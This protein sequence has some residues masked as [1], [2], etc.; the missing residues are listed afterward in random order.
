MVFLRSRAPR[1]LVVLAACLLACAAAPALAKSDTPFGGAPWPVPGSIEAEDFDKGGQGVSYYNPDDANIYGQY[2][3]NAKISIE[4]STDAGGGYDIAATRTGE[5]MNYTVKV[6]TAGNYTLQVRV[7][8]AGQGGTFHFLVDGA[9]A[10]ATQTVPDTGGW[11]SWTTLSTTIALPAGQHVVQ[12]H[13][14]QVSAATANVGNF[15]RFTFVAAG[16]G[17]AARQQ[18]LAYL[19]GV[20]GN[21]ALVGQHD[22]YNSDPAGATNEVTSITGRAPAYWN[23]DFGFGSDQLANRQKM[24]DEAISQY[25]AGALTGLM[26]HACAPTGDESCSWNDIGGAH[27]AHLSDAQFAQLVTPGTALYKTWIARLDTLAGY[28]QQIKDAGQAVMF[29]PLHEMNQCVFWWA[30]HGGPNG[31]ARLYQITHDY[32]ALTKGLDNIIW[33]WNVQDFGSLASDLKT[34]DPGAAYHDFISLDVYDGGYTT[35]NYN[36]MLGAAA[37]QMIAIGECQVMPTASELAAQP[38]W[39]FAM[40][41]PDFIDQNRA[42]LPTL[43]GAGNVL[44]LDEMAGWH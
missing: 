3:P 11:Q 19:H 16:S 2:R 38:K 34:Y 17:N 35:A 21:H 32:L 7:A 25:R 6:A 30:C 28:F 43:Y 33:N 1:R 44:T 20:S 41:W 40:L 31:S 27:P 24:I 29:R 37:G 23:A 36:L 4:A 39:I 18:V 22:K 8:S 42:S 15:N 26:Y 5:W 14:D 9:A 13:L 12:L 10:T